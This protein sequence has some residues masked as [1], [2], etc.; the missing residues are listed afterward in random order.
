MTEAAVARL[1]GRGP[2]PVRGQ[3]LRRDIAAAGSAESD[4]KAA[5]ASADSRLRPGGK[6]D[7]SRAAPRA[8]MNPRRTSSR[9]P[10]RGCRVLISDEA[11][12]RRRGRRACWC[13]ST[14]TITVCDARAGTP[15]AVQEVVDIAQ[16]AGRDARERH[17]VAD[18]VRSPGRR[19]TSTVDVVA[20]ARWHRCCGRPRV[21]AP[22]CALGA[23]TVSRAVPDEGRGRRL[24]EERRGRRRTRPCP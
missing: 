10:C 6:R 11:L 7:E 5:L 12:D 13:V 16:L 4:L 21:D 20:G 3:A 8:S 18:R 14:K 22:A 15:A 9:G 2:D 17:R 1:R 19:E 24:E 23:G